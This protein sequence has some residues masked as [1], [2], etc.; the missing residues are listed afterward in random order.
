MPMAAGWDQDIPNK[1]LKWQRLPM[2]NKPFEVKLKKGLVR[3][4]TI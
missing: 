4:A 2:E 1:N 3:N